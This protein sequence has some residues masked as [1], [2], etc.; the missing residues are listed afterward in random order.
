MIVKP[1]RDEKVLQP[2]HSVNV[3]KIIDFTDELISCGNGQPMYLEW[4]LSIYMTKRIV[5]KIY[6][7]VQMVF[8]RDSTRRKAKKLGL[9]GWVKNEPDKTVKIIAEGEEGGL[10]E[11]I[12]WCYNGPM[13]AKVEKVDIEWGEAKGEFK[14]FEIKYE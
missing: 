13:L 5:L 12:D 2:S 11:L 3:N 10:K 1:F 14:E 6:G 9:V 8:Y 4:P 7:R